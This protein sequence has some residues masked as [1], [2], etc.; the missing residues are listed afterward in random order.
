MGSLKW[1]DFD[2]AAECPCVDRTPL[3]ARNAVPR[4]K[5]KIAAAQMV[6]SHLEGFEFEFAQMGGAAPNPTKIE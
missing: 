1:S 2:N 5:A 4:S 3:H 6:G